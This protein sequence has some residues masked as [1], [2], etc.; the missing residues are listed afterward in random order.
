MWMRR[1]KGDMDERNDVMPFSCF[2]FQTTPSDK[3]SKQK[4]IGFWAWN[5]ALLLLSGISIGG[6]SL[7]LALGTKTP[8][9][10]RTYVEN[11]L[12]LLLNL[13]PILALIVLLYGLTGR[14]WCAYLI[15]AAL[16]LGL[17]AGNYYKLLFRNDPLMFEDLLLLKEAGDM[18]GKYDLSQAGPIPVILLCA[19]VVLPFLIL[20]ARGRPRGRLRAAVA[21][22]GAAVAVLL[23]PLVTD[24]TTYTVHAANYD[25]VSNIWSATEQYI[26]HGFVYPFLYSIGTAIDHGPPPRYNAQQAQADLERYEDAE[27]PEDRRVNVIGVMLEAYNDFSRLGTPTFIKDPY[28]VWHQLEAEGY[29]GSLVTNIFSG[30]TVDTER[31]FITG[32]SDLVDIRRPTNSYAWY[33]RSQGYRVE[34]MHPF[35]DWFYNRKNVNENLGFQD[36]YFIENYFGQYTGGNVATDDIF[37]SQLLKTYQAASEGGAPYFNFSVTYQ[38]HG[39]YDPE[40]SWWGDVGEFV[41]DDGTY[42]LAQQH[43]LNNYFGSVNNTGWQLKTFTDSLRTDDTPVVLVLFGDHNP[44][45]GLSAY[46]SIGLD[47]DVSTREGFENYYCTRY[48]IWANDAAKEVLGCDFTGEGPTISPCY[49]MDQVFQLC[50]WE[51]P[52]YMQASKAVGEQI[53]VINNPTGF[54]YEKDTFTNLLTQEG[55]NTLDAFYSLQY[56]YRTHFRYENFK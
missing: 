27:I 50:G 14:V 38:G 28:T 17:S 33:F 47:I 9:F 49:L 32:F 25:R 12:I 45:L 8:G 29:S 56:Y 55:Q 21:A 41:A 16:V 3:W 10:L 19:A 15:T 37:F 30:G 48:I 5:L 43:I 51:G 13:L 26:A 39:P 42:T 22:V 11:P 6:L 46:E 1:E 31:C 20:L 40:V 34:G 7:I 36:Y 52:A 2:L 18:A 35:Y 54:C 44:G 23:A 4:R 24:Q 53:P